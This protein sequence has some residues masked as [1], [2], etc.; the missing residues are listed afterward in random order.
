MKKKRSEQEDPRSASE[1][2]SELDRQPMTCQVDSD[3]KILSIGPWIMYNHS[4]KF[5]KDLIGVFS[6]PVNRQ[7]NRQ[8]N[9]QMQVK[10]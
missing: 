9:Y 7:T 2:K 3:T 10:T 4:I 5:R 1:Q 8:T 6:N